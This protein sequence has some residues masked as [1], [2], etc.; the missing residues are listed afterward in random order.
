MNPSLHAEVIF[1]KNTTFSENKALWET[2][3]DRNIG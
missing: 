3:I 1:V 2:G